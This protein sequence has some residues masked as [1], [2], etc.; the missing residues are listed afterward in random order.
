MTRPKVVGAAMAVLAAALLGACNDETEPAKPPVDTGKIAAAIKADVDQLSNDFNAHDPDRVVGHDAPDVVQMAH[1]VA[2]T[3][4]TTADLVANR[5]LFASDRIARV[6]LAGPSVAVA[7][8]G[9][10]AVYRSTYVLTFINPKTRKPVTES[11]NYLAGYR[12]QPNGAWRMAWSVLSD[13][14]PTP[15][16]ARDTRS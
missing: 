13:T 9:D 16:A 1:G 5:Q 6:A 15:A 2:N 8:S 10:M 12:L 4:G 3:S 7:A 14:G 11:G